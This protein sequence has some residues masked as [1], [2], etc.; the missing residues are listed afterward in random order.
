MGLSMK[1]KPDLMPRKPTMDHY[2]I[3][4]MVQ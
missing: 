2:R 1:M 3:P 4:Q